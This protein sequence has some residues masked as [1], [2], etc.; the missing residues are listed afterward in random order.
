MTRARTTVNQADALR[1]HIMAMDMMSQHGFSKIKA[2]AVLVR[3][4]LPSVNSSPSLIGEIDEAMRAIEYLAV[5][6][7]NCIN[8]DAEK[9]AANHVDVV[10]RAGGAHG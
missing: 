4:A 5:D 1:D 6:C 8:N 2:I 3:H 10:T 7:E 9:A